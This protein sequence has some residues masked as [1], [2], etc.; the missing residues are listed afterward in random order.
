MPKF[1]VNLKVKLF[2]YAFHSYVIEAD[3]K[4]QA[5]EQA[6]QMMTPSLAEVKQCWTNTTPMFVQQGVI[7][8]SVKWT[9][10]PMKG[11]DDEKENQ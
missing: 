8:N 4:K 3:S 9:E 6:Q 2:Q 10:R 7:V 1:K 5:R 11:N